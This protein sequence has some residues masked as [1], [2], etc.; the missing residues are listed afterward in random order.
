MK[1]TIKRVWNRAGIF[2]VCLTLSI[3]AI[4]VTAVGCSR[5]LRPLG[6]RNSS[7]TSAASLSRG[8]D[9]DS[10]RDRAAIAHVSREYGRLPMRFE[11][12]QETEDQLRVKSSAEARFI[13]RGVG[14]AL[15]L[16]PGEAVL[17]LRRSERKQGEAR[18]PG[19]EAP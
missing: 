13:S 11:L 17:G 16:T 7:E 8:G 6:S 19:N 15:F 10:S 9:R 18:E 14:Y 4:A 3:A 1:A 12:H 2:A 5:G